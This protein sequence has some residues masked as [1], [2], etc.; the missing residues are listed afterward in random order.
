MRKKGVCIISG[1]MDSALSGK[2]AEVEGYDI[3]ALHSTIGPGGTRKE[4]RGG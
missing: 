4:R 1:G 2:I 3:I